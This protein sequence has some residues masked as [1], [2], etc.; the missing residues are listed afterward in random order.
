MRILQINSVCGI[1]STGRICTD[2]ADLLQ[3]N[4]D[5]CL[6]VF[7]REAAGINS[8]NISLKI[9]NYATNVI[10]YLNYIFHDD[11]GKGSWIITKRLVQKIKKYNP[12][13]IHLHNIHGHYIN[14]NVLMD[15][16]AEA[17]IPAVFSLYDCWQF[18]G[19]CA[20][21]DYVGCEKWKNQCA[22]CPIQEKYPL[23]KYWI[24]RSAKNFLNKKKRMKRIK[25]K[26]ILPGSYWLE[27]MVRESFLKDDYIITVQS[28]LDLAKYRPITSDIKKKHGIEG[29]T[30]VLCVASTWS[31]A[32][33][34]HL[35]L[36]VAD[37]IKGFARLVVVGA[38]SDEAAKTHANIICIEQ[39]N[40]IDELCMWY[41]AADVYLNLTLQ[42]TLGLTNVEALACG[43]PVVT[44]A[45]GGCT[46]CIDETCGI[47]VRRDD[48]D[49][50]IKAVMNIVKNQPFKKEACFA[51]AAKFDKNLLYTK[52]LDVY[53][54]LLHNEEV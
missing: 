14:Y 41:T 30:V 42:E 15:F 25:N 4:G 2:I 24:D 8:K 46:E 37:Q 52:Y 12:D 39:T 38:L 10:H 7:G 36:K 51:K 5:E 16:I 53:Q 43:T 33:G 13:I 22:N 28:G 44:F 49:A 6:I 27:S 26:I 11:D 34:A 20:H 47:A 31:R 50:A 21:F 19:N 17:K 48:V 45:S 29:E 3:K 18:T 54:E 32:K 23:D 35:L 1:R 40:S 9:G